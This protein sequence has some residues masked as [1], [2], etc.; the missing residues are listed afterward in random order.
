MDF[1]ETSC[2]F[3]SYLLIL[4]KIIQPYL[5]RDIPPLWVISNFSQNIQLHK[6]YTEHFIPIP[7]P[8]QEDYFQPLKKLC[9]LL[10]FLYILYWWGPEEAVLGSNTSPW[11]DFVYCSQ[12]WKRRHKKL[13]KAL[14]QQVEKLAFILLSFHTNTKF[15]VHGFGPNYW[16]SL[17]LKTIMWSL[18]L[19]GA[20]VSVIYVINSESVTEVVVLSV[21]GSVMV[22]PTAN[23]LS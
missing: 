3:I 2:S 1:R 6:I 17:W 18:D 11:A 19:S 9:G 16:N 4:S 23:E 7:A 21:H 8:P 13:R 22:L 5:I 15:S 12:K 10:G 20:S 14:E